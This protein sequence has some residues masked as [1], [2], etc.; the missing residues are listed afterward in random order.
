MLGVVDDLAALR[1]EV[2]RRVLDHREILLERGAKDL[3]D[4]QRPGLPD[5]R[6]DGHAAIE[7]RLELGVLVR[8]G[9]GA[10][11][12]A[13]GRQ[14]RMLQVQLLRL[15]KESDVA[16]IGARE[17]A[18]DVIDAEVI[19]FL[20]N[21]QFVRDGKADAFTLRAI[22]QRGVVD[23]D[24]GA[25]ASR[26]RLGSESTLARELFQSGGR[27]AHTGWSS[28]SPGCLPEGTRI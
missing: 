26:R 13:E 17:P 9:S 19:E 8:L 14:A 2:P 5:D 25:H 10:A 7:E 28:L 11:R 6:R 1:H 12:R 4:V 24:G 23:L 15:L 18:L 27:E 20:R 21:Q 16:R 3:R 22:A